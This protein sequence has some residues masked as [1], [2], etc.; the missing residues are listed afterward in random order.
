MSSRKSAIVHDITYNEVAHRILRHQEPEQ[1]ALSMGLRVDSVK[2]ILQKKNFKTKIALLQ[3]KQYG[4][5]NQELEASG[6]DLRKELDAQAYKAF[7]ALTILME[8]AANEGVRTNIAQDFMDRAGY[9]RKPKEA[10]QLTVNIHPIDADVI[11]T[12]LKTAASG[13]A[14]LIDKGVLVQKAAEVKRPALEDGN[15]KSITELT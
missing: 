3:E 6:R 5:L 13:R 7:D 9:E 1:I 2:Q 10:P 4:T 15:N 14:K 12:A 8:T 11:A